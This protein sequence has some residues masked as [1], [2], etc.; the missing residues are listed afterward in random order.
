[1]N[2]QEQFW[3]GEFGT[4]YSARNQGPHLIASNLAL[5][6]RVLSRT[7]GITSVLEF[8]ANVGMNLDALGLLLPGADL[9]GLEFNDH[10]VEILG[11]KHEAIH[12]SVLAWET[13]RQWDMVLC[14]GLG[15]HISPDDL[16][17]LYE[18]LYLSARKYIVLAE[19]YSKRPQEVEYRGNKARMWKRDFATE[20][21]N[22]YPDLSLIDYGF[23]SEYDA[24][25]LDNINWWLLSK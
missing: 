10:A 16:W 13:K 21:M 9:C 5:F 15:I 19:Y 17:K 2:D 18:N 7:R 3:G 22:R 12:D 20:L 6:S 24:F 4:A 8:G 14:K 25:P 23:V 1:M 11:G